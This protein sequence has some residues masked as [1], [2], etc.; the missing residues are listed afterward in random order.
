MAA[1]FR[2]KFIKFLKITGL[3][4]GVAFVLLFFA[5]WSIRFPAVQN[6]LL[7]LVTDIASKQ[8]E[9]EVSIRQV[10]IDFPAMAVLEGVIL[11]DQKGNEMLKLE[12]LKISL[13]SVSLWKLIFGSE[14]VQNLGFS[15]I[16]LVSPYFL[17]YKSRQDS[18]LNLSFL[19]KPSKKEKK[20][21]RL[22]FDLEEILL[23]DG[24]FRFVD[25][26]Q[27]DSLLALRHKLNFSNL[28]FQSIEGTFSVSMTADFD[29]SANLQ[30]LAFREERTGFKLDSLKSQFGMRKIPPLVIDPNCPEDG[31]LQEFILTNTFIRMAK[32]RVDLD[33]STRVA[34]IGNLFKIGA[35]D[36]LHAIFR[37]S[38]FDYSF[39]E[40]FTEDTFALKGVPFIE[41]PVTW[42]MS[43]IKGKG[44]KLGFGVQTRLNADVFLQDYTDVKSLKLDVNLR[45]SQVN[46][47]ELRGMIPRLKIPIEGTAMANGRVYGDLDKLRSDQMDL[48]FGRQTKLN[49]RFILYKVTDAED[50]TMDVTLKQGQFT[51]NELSLLLPFLKL[52]VFAGAAELIQAN[53]HFLG[54]ISDF[55]VDV[56]FSANFGAGLAGL[57][58]VFPPRVPDVQYEGTVVLNELNYNKLGLGPLFKS[59]KINFNGRVK[60]QGFNI[61]TMDASFEGLFTHSD[62]MGYQI[63]TLRTFPLIIK[64]KTIKGKVELR[65]PEGNGDFTLDLNLAD[66]PNSYFITGDVQKLDLKHYSLWRDSFLLTSILDIKLAGDSLDN[67]N[68]RAKFFLL[69]LDNP[70]AGEKLK[71]SDF[72][73]KTRENTAK[74]KNSVVNSSLFD[75][76]LKGDFSFNEGKKLFTRLVQEG[77]LYFKNNDTL[78]SAYYN[79]KQL[80][81]IKSVIHFTLQPKPQGN[82]LLSFMGLPIFI[83]NDAVAEGTFKAEDYDQVDFNFVA[84]SLAFWGIGF[85]QTVAALNFT[86]DGRQ[87]SVIGVGNVDV[88]L[89][90]VNEKFQLESVNFEPNLLDNTLEYWLSG[91]QTAFDNSIRLNATTVF[92]TTGI[93]THI[94]PRVSHI[95]TGTSEWVISEGNR[96]INRGKWIQISDLDLNNAGQRI[97]LNGIVSERPEDILRAMVDNLNLTSLNEI[98]PFK[99]DFGGVIT[100]MRGEISGVFKHPQVYVNGDVKNFRYQMIDSVDLHLTALLDSDSLKNDLLLRA[101]ASF[102]G[103][104]AL[105]GKGRYNFANKRNPLYVR[106]DSSNLPLEW[107]ETFTTPHV[108][109]LKGQVQV[110]KFLITGKLDSLVLNGEAHFE[111]EKEGEIVNFFV[112]FLGQTFGLGNQSEL[113][114]DSRRIRFP[115]LIVYDSPQSTHQAMLDG[116]IRH[117]GLKEFDFDLQLSGLNNFQVMNTTA[118]DNDNFY[119]RVVLNDGVAFVTGDLEKIELD[120][121]FVTGKGTELSIPLTDYSAASRLDFVKFIGSGVSAPEEQSAAT[122]FLLRM[123]ANATPDAKVRLIFD[124]QVGDILEARG[125]GTLNLNVSD[126]GDFQM[127]GDYTATEGNYL[128]TSQ[129][130]VNKKFQV[131]PGGTIRWGGDPYEAQLNVTAVY[132][133]NALASNIFGENATSRIPVEIRMDLSGFLS[134]PQITLSLKLDQATDDQVV[135]IASYFKNIQYDEQELNRQVVS[136]LIFGAFAPA[137]SGGADQN[138]SIAG[139]GISNSVSEL[140]SNQLN[141][142]LSQALGNN[143]L[144]VTVASDQFQDIQLGI[145]AQLFGDKVTLEREGTIVGRNNNGS[146]SIGNVSLTIRLLPTDGKKNKKEDTQEGPVKQQGQLVLEVFNRESSTLSSATTNTTGAGIFFKKDFDNLI[147]LFGIRKKQP[148]K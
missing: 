41:G 18:V 105:I 80:D 1:K 59:E 12:A 19:L 68:G 58:F 130:V 10:G 89:L 76:D 126:E 70:G 104:K 79:E 45:E 51:L 2:K 97:R 3:T 101:E 24:R 77:K 108:T 133:V 109:H 87:N 47:S 55:N 114:F 44:L 136:L 50:L 142:W 13:I 110:D 26:T 72:V 96:I 115:T 43:E 65:D 85:K 118:R 121:D 143:N 119:G 7:P 9:A 132:K 146:V 78:T 122:G 75:L 113:V 30:Q 6:R 86:K 64:N 84:D 32:S 73:I 82:K 60:G 81:S 131:V 46:F 48:S 117:K 37:H 20:P 53:G 125:N 11:Q 116:E 31:F 95:R 129:N 94:N 145:K 111:G 25:S 69:E 40:Y 35:T 34:N 52:P 147:E 38:E 102:R 137:S 23:S 74:N 100:R 42:S 16:E 98:L 141:Y 71:I 54:S 103:K 120:A 88:G 135:G 107:I 139:S 90:R 140:V 91:K 112:P 14:D 36:T 22:A 27:N 4:L 62:M 138:A 106:V 15:K 66:Q 83:S 127:F 128:F 21:A 61:A 8:L 57:H 49:T 63:D 33:A 17:L 5:A 67:L 39:I 123:R 148:G 99:A 56:G 124:E 93:Y 144:D 92:D 28:D 134:A 29:L